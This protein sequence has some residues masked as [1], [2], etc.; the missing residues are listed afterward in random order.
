V[1]GTDCIGSY[2]SDHNNDGLYSSLK[3][4]LGTTSCFIHC[5]LFL[6]FIFR[7]VNLFY[8]LTGNLPFTMESKKNFTSLYF[9]ILQGCEIPQTLSNGRW[10]FRLAYI[11]IYGVFHISHKICTTCDKVCQWLATDRWFSP[12]PS[13]SSTNNTDRHDIDEI[14]LKVALNTI[15]QTNKRK[16]FQMLG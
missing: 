15:K 11:Y 3:F 9:S 13:V 7:G 14:L 12:G 1:I 2:K 16:P 10:I 6:Y 5:I 4:V 8:L